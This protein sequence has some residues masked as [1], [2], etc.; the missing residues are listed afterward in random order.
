MARRLAEREGGHVARRLDAVA[1]RAR[2]RAGLSS[3]WGTF[4]DGRSVT[5]FGRQSDFFTANVTPE[6][7]DPVRVDNSIG[8]WTFTVDQPPTRR[9]PRGGTRSDRRGRGTAS[10]D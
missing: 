2:R 1:A 4:D 6:N 3:S 7:S 10:H 5:K 9:A 8:S